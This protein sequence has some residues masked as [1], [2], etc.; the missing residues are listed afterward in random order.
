MEQA[1][2]KIPGR[3]ILCVG[4]SLNQTTILHKIST[5]LPEVD[6]SFTPFFTEGSESVFRKTSLLDHTIMGGA[7]RRATLQYI[8]EN[9]L[10]MDEGGRNGPYDLVL[11]CTDLI[12]QRS[13][14]KSRLIL[15]QE[16]ITEK[17]GLTYQLV[18][19]LGLPRVLANTA[20]TGLSN[21]YD[22]FCVASP[23]YRALFIQKGVRP[24]K[25]IVTGIPNFDQADGYK[26][27]SFPYRNYVLV[28][29][30]SIR[31]TF[32]LD[33]RITFLKKARRI[34]GKKKVIFKLHPNENQDR[35]EEEI[36]RI[37]P[38]SLIFRDGNLHE[39]IANC[40][41]LV[42][43]NTSAVYTAAALGKKVYSLIPESTIKD[44]MPMQNGGTSALHI[45]EVCRKV[46]NTPLPEKQQ[47]VRIPGHSLL[48]D[49]LQ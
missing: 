46:L 39:M 2:D 7:H 41:I 47:P 33:D 13:L 30:S 4:G 17:E 26:N 9:H 22:Y 28:A 24:E 1:M 21:A 32:G 29:T 43:Q 31:E 8:H 48:P 12:V 16:G 44:L 42:A 35:A 6:C 23:G 38:T 34:A 25:I 10:Q 49:W 14:R 15:V 20:A 37:F 11:T 27:N 18:K 36:R 40:K 45:A 19:Y 3:R 5:C